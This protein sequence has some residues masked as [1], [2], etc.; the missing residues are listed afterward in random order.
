[1]Y[2]G[3]SF[4]TV[5]SLSF[6]FSISHLHFIRNKWKIATY[7]EPFFYF[8]PG[9]EP[10]RFDRNPAGF[11]GSGRDFYRDKNIAVLSPILKWNGTRFT[12]MEKTGIQDQTSIAFMI[13]APHYYVKDMEIFQILCQKAVFGGWTAPW[14]LPE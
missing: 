3:F 7:C 13:H 9:T 10:G 2:D 6:S 11:S 8:D 1:M 5:G 12:S 4:L 14:V